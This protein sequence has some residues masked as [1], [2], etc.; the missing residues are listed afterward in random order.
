MAGVVYSEKPPEANLGPYFKKVDAIVCL[1]G[2]KG[3]IRRAI[4]LFSQK[5]GRV[6]YISGLGPKVQMRDVLRDAKWSAPL[7]E[8]HIILERVATNTIEN[9]EQVAKYLKDQGLS[10]VLLVTSS[11]HAR[12]AHYIFSRVLPRNSRIEVVSFEASPFDSDGWW[13][14]PL[15]IWVTTSEFLKFFLSYLRLS[16]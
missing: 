16:F 6:L 14:D 12:R 15:G 13:K 7:D 8:S 3:R 11:Y 9:A 2:G 1:T 4:E 10:Q 5:Y